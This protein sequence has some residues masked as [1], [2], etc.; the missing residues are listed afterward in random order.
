MF[1]EDWSSSFT[2]QG[3]WVVLLSHGWKGFAGRLEDCNLLLRSVFRD[4]RNR[5]AAVREDIDSN[6]FLVSIFVL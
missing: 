6:T 4:E 3:K 5:S 1:L 2:M